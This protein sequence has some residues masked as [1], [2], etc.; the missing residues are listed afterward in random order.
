MVRD[1]S[2]QNDLIEQDDIISKIRHQK[3]ADLSGGEKRY[4]EL[5]L[6]LQQDADCYLLDE[7]F[8]G[9]APHMQ[10]HIQQII[11]DNS[12]N[13]GF[14]ISDHHFH[15]VLAITT[16]IVLLQNGACRKIE[17]RKDLEMFYVP[18]GTFDE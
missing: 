10:N 2:K 11:L 5:M 15:T 16:R 4:L 3:I 17:S 13:K 18:E 1:I 8:S 14:I 12:K 6:L 9:V 7:P